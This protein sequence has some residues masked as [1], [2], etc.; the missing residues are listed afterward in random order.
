MSQK[1]LPL[2]PTQ[3]GYIER[4]NKTFKEEVLDFALCNS[5]TEVNE[6]TENWLRQYNEERHHESLGNLTPA[7]F[8]MNNSPREVSIFG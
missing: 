4:F 3:N 1:P 7:E 2:Q 8:L 5:L 6:I